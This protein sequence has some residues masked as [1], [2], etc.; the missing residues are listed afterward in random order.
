MTALEQLE[1]QHTHAQMR[2]SL[3]TTISILRKAMEDAGTPPHD[4]RTA[5]RLRESW[6][7]AT[8]RHEEA[9]PIFGDVPE[10]RALLDELGSVI[11][12]LGEMIS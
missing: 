1:H 10:T 12:A 9:L 7:V 3:R 8:M 5:F 11:E 4:P 2:E 6:G